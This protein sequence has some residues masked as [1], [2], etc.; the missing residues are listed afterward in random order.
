MVEEAGE[1]RESICLLPLRFNEWSPYRQFFFLCL[2]HMEFGFRDPCRNQ[3]LEVKLWK[4][5]VDVV[6][7]DQSAFT[8]HTVCL[9]MIPVLN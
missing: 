4:K 9:C 8:D 7:T 5:K 6:S 1:E 3:G 2:L